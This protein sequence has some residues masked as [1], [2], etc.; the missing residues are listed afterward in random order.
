MRKG[1]VMWNGGITTDLARSEVDGKLEWAN[2]RM[3]LK[4]ASKS[5]GLSALPRIRK[6]VGRVM[7]ELGERIQGSMLDRQAGSSAAI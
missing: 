5:G 3:L 7:I 2:D 1:M 4:Q 6:A